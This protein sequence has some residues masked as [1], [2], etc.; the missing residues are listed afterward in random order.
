MASG[1]VCIGQH[2]DAD[3][4]GEIMQEPGTSS[5]QP[6]GTVQGG[7][8]RGCAADGILLGT[9]LGVSALTF[10]PFTSLL[11]MHASPQWQLLY[12]GATYVGA[13][14]AVLL[15]GWAS[16]LPEGS[17]KL[18]LSG[19]AFSLFFLTPAFGS[20]CGINA[21]DH[22]AGWGID[23]LGLVS[24]GALLWAVVVLGIAA[25]I[26]FSGFWNRL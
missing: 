22:L 23:G 3:Q 13:I 18:A 8:H 14:A 24:L 10:K 25:A 5:Q 17:R 6:N 7:R 20:F 19:L 16:K 9:F 26:R 15:L 1:Q 2:K 4:H 21:I 11:E 12:G